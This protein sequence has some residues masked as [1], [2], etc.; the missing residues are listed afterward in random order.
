M[1][2]FQSTEQFILSQVQLKER[3]TFNQ[4]YCLFCWHSFSFF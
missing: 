3:I 4:W 2:K 1:N